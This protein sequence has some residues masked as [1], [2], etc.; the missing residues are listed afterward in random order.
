[1]MSSHLESQTT[2]LPRSVCSSDFC[3]SS[4]MSESCDPE[5]AGKYNK[6]HNSSVKV[7]EVDK[8]ERVGYNVGN[9]ELQ[10]YL[11]V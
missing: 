9:T 5:A 11:N 6:Y 10:R 3:L 2:F 7:S 1:M 4:K 8:K